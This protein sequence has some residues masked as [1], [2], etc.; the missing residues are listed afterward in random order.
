MPA[1]EVTGLCKTYRVYRKREGLWASVTGLFHRE[2]KSVEAVRQ[3]GFTI[4]AGEMVAFLGPNGAGK[5]TTLKLL[6]GLIYPTSG[7]ARVLDYVPWKREHAYRRRFS[8]VMGQKNQLWWDLPAQESFRLHK[9]IYRIEPEQFRR[10]M[11]ELTDLL[12]VRKL[13]AQP[14][15]E[16]SLGER[17]RMELI[18]A[19]LHSPD[20]L[21]LDEPT[22]GLDV[23]SQRKVQEF[24]KYYQAERKITV[25][26]TSHYMKDVEALCRRAII[27]NEGEIK[28]DGPLAEIVDRFSRHKVISLQFTG[29][30]V[31]GD[32][33]RF[34]TVVKTEPPR[35]NLEVPRQHISEVLTALL[36]TYSIEDVGV[37]ER[38][39]EEVIAEMFT[40]GRRKTSDAPHAVAAPTPAGSPG[41]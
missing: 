34:G 37:Q 41:R 17:M 27:I 29:S 36:N 35:A 11:D 2:Y 1:I 14:V 21:Y 7:A 4:E 39:L 5:T 31:P 16:L 18:A 20:V 19:L 3:V 15:R 12:E 25:L 23:V 10:R 28:H 26:L 24:L 40:E 8:L 38:P 33:G 30:D 13:I 32:L 22:I 9:E 6:S